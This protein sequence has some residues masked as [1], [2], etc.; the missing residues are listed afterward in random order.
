MIFTIEL[1]GT[2]IGITCRHKENKDFFRDYLTDEAAEISVEPSCEDICRMEKTLQEEVG[3]INPAPWFIENNAI[4]GL[5]AEAL[6]DHG[7]LLMHGSAVVLD[8]EAYIF[9][10]NS[11]TGKSTHTRLWIEQF[12][13]RAWMLN[14]DKPMIRI[15]D[16]GIL[17]Y[18]TPWDGKH[19]LSRNASVPLNAIA[20]I[21]RGEDNHIEPVGSVESVTAIFPHVIR[22]QDPAKM[23]KVMEMETILVKH[24]G[25]YRLRCN[26]DPEAAVVAYEGMRK[27]K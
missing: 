7:V 14:D 22:P 5:L 21:S 27:K 18:G 25:V 1:A 8:N 11:G 13:G 23:K 16:S 12:A 17:A 20:L 26:M 3:T 19:H 24:V 10:A 9:M 4:H 6:I 15:S 2:C